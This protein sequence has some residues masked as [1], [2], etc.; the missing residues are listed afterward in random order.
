[1]SEKDRKEY[2]R[3]WARKNRE[4]IKTQE[5]EKARRKALEAIESVEKI[6]NTHVLIT[7]KDGNKHFI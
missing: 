4:R 5:R 2:K 6:D 7:D 1:M 3:E